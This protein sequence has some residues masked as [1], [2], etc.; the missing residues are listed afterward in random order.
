MIEIELLVGSIFSEIEKAARNKAI[1]SIMADVKSL[2]IPDKRAGDV[3]RKMAWRIANEQL[4]IALEC[5][6]SHQAFLE[7]ISCLLKRH[8]IVWLKDADQL[9]RI[10][11]EVTPKNWQ[12]LHRI[13]SNT[14]Y[15]RESQNKEE[16]SEGAGARD[17]LQFPK[18]SRRR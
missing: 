18:E 10:E 8:G 3:F 7:C 9:S 6:T 5:A 1:N 13:C 16:E 11:R 2:E 17:P 14:L 4:G 12:K 15:C